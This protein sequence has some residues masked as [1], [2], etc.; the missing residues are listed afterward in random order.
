MHGPSLLLWALGVGVLQGFVHCAGMCGPFVLAFSVSVAGTSPSPDVWHII[1]RAHIPH[2]A[3]RIAAFTVLGMVFGLLGSLVDVVS[4]PTGLTAAAAMACGGLMLVWAVDEWKSGR[5]GAWIERWSLLRVPFVGR[6]LRAV[7]DR[8]TPVGAFAA[9][10][11]LGL[12]PCGLLFAMLLGAAATGSWMMGGLTLLAFGVGTA[13]SLMT[14]ALAGWYGRRRLRRPVFARMAS[15]FIAMS[16]VLF[17][18]RGM[19]VNHWIPTVSRW[20]F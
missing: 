5:A 7:M 8:R 13:P 11:L 15:S 4:R 16:G 2:N 14:V 20:L 12:H 1:W 3:G 18:L 10:A 19:A 17:I 9:G 6:R